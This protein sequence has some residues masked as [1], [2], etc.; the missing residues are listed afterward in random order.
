MSA[1]GRGRTEVIPEVVFLGKLVERITAGKIRVPRFQRTFVWRQAD[2]HALLDSVLRG[3]PIGSILIWETARAI[4]TTG[5]VGP[6]FEV[7]APPDGL[8]GYLLDGQQRVSTLTGTLRLPDGA[9]PIVDQVDWRIYFDLDSQEFLRAPTG[10]PGPQHFPVRSLLDTAGFFAVPSYPVRSR[11]RESGG[12]MAGRGGSSRERV[13]GL[14]AS[15]DSHPRGGPGQRRD[16]L[17][18]TQSYRTQDDGRRDGL[19][20]DLEEGQFHLAEKLNALKD[21][22]GG[23][24]FGNLRVLLLRAVL[25]ASTATARLAMLVKPEVGGFRRS[26]TRRQRESRE[27]STFSR[28]WA[29]RPIDCCRTFSSCCS[30]SSSGYARGPAANRPPLALVLGHVVHRLVRRRPAQVRRAWGRSG[31]PRQGRVAGFSVVADAPAQ[32]FPKRFDGRS[33]RA[34]SALPRVEKWRRARSRA[35]ARAERAWATY[36]PTR[37][38][39][40]SRAVPR[41]PRDPPRVRSVRAICPTR[42]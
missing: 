21:E 13:P 15:G 36:A 14:P 12:T 33:R 4:E 40:R 9:E 19:R 3:F 7:G 25:A 28:G 18:A 35:T 23:R 34:L 16:R 38:R 31:E 27:R 39:W 1:G 6:I 5:R 2:L 24:G 8:V 41:M 26:S 20:A 10:G 30:A 29:S 22:L 11:P 32:P 17:R 37:S 42:R